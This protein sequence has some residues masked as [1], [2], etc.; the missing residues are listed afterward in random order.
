MLGVGVRGE[1]QPGDPARIGPYRLVEVL[2]G[3]G[4]GRVYLG[5]SAGGRPVAVKVIRPELAADAEFRGRF[6]QEVAAARRVNGFY[7]AVVVDADA[8]GP[9]PWLATAHVDAPSLEDAVRDGGPL[10]AAS[11]AGLAAGLAEGLAAI[12]AVGLVHRDLKPS[13]VLLAADGPRI[14]DF[15]IAWMAEAPSLTAV[16]LLI[17]SPGFLS[18][19]Q[20]EP[21]REVGPASDVFNLGALLCYAATGRGPWGAGYVTTL[22]YRVVHEE[23]D[24]AG[25]PRE[26][27]DL[28]A[29]CLAKDPARR[30]TPAQILAELG[31]PDD[32]PA[33]RP[34]WPAAVVSA[35]V[36]P[37]PNLAGDLAVAAAA[38]ARYGLFAGSQPQ[39]TV[40]V[41]EVP[42]APP[43]YQPRDDLI[44]ELRAA[45]QGVSV[46]RA[47][48]GMRG[49][50]KTQ[51]AAAYARECIDAGWR[52]VAWVNAEDGPGL[53]NGLATVA[54]RLGMNR[55][56]SDLETLGGQVRNRLEADG[57][58]CLIVF[59]NV[60]DF[61]VVRRYVPAL[62]SPQAVLTTTEAIAVGSREPVQVGA[63]SAAEAFAFLAERTGRD[64]PD[65]AR[66]LAEELGC[67]PLALAQAAAVIAGQRLTY[68]RYLDRLRAHPA[69]KYLPPAKGDPYPRGAAE[70]I[71]LSVEAVMAADPAGLSA[72]LLGVVSLLSAE[73]AARP[74]LYLGQA[75]GCW[76]ADEEEV[77]EAL[78]RLVDAS[79]LSF[80]GDD[81]VQSHRMVMRVTRER[82]AHDGT[83]PALA[84]KAAGLLAARADELGDPWQDIAGLHDCVSQLTALADHLAALPDEP[85]K[86][87]RSPA[88][89]AETPWQMVTHTLLT[90]RLWGLFWL[91]E[92]GDSAAQAVELA[93]RLVPDCERLLGEAHRDTLSARRNLGRAY[94]DGGRVDAAVPLLELAA[95]D[96]ERALGA[97]DPLTL[98][99]RKDIGIAYAYQGRMDDAVSLLET[100]AADFG[101]APD[102]S[103]LEIN[104]AHNDLAWAYKDAGRYAEAG[105]LYE[106][107]LMEGEQLRGASH[108]DTLTTRNNLASTYRRL[109]R[110]GEAITMFE[111]VLADFER[112]LGLLHPNTLTVRNNLA[113]AIRAAGRPA[114]A[115]PLYEAVLA[116]RG[117]VLGAAHWHTL[118]SRGNLARAY[119]DIGRLDEAVTLFEQ[120]AVGLDGVLGAGHPA[121]VKA[122]EELAS[123][124][125]LAQQPA[126]PG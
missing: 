60:R 52:L 9:V 100:V 7:T 96:C 122:R 67:L 65:G 95:A 78:A 103:R 125:A 37:A 6:R 5:R 4:M 29:R 68:R 111:A 107:V 120:E 40:V 90:L 31:D 80:V 19:E 82:A 108:P 119:R 59:D 15:G 25:V 33:R 94:R 58:R 106:T 114:E 113:S 93:E 72:D 47:V 61:D 16:G 71:L 28:V 79:L 50:G 75:A 64:D 121:A 84:A 109:G 11:L 30:P 54:D 76:E 35:A 92:V 22:L 105:S 43:A 66:A 115:V 116:D 101:R 102:A 88:P 104:S 83:L 87:G 8:D 24:L 36:V 62:G 26:I 42:Q 32:A 110:E 56:G 124:R 89:A 39:T 117:Q 14:I 63:F 21:E 81:S 74:L 86:A 91:N 123:T 27:R 55:S 20:A 126:D 99:T 46:V 77:D 41:G 112:V 23:P 34:A 45:G 17:G 57:D 3:G 38:G 98:L 70:A 1:L 13:N 118:E 69:G 18:P 73:G 97:A 2:G 12:H 51:L 44:A 49:V 53:L 48:T 85:E 10:P